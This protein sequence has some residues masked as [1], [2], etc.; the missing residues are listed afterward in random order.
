[1]RDLWINDDDLIVATNGRSFWISDATRPRRQLN[2]AIANPETYISEAH[3]FA[4][5]VAYR[6]R[7]DTNTDTP[8]PADEPAGENPPDGAIIDYFLTKPALGPVTLEI[9]NAQG[10]LVRRDSSEDKSDQTH[11]EW[12]NELIQPH[13]LR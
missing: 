11:T 7:R 2:P 1:M 3:L 10:K 12:D 9:L 5:A 6:I 13:W 8:L 4:P